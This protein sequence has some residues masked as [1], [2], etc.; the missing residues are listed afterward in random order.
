MRQQRIAVLGALSIAVGLAGSLLMAGTVNLDLSDFNDDVM[1]GMDDTMKALDSEIATHEVQ[2]VTRDTQSLIQG[3]KWAQDYFT[4]KGNLQDAIRWAAQGQ[5]LA[6]SL[7]KAAQAGDFDTS[8][9]K[10]D[11]LVKNCRACHDVYK[12]PDI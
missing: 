10:Y 11:A 6:D 3:L 5:E 2:S 4:R 7:A 9:N 12:P 8:L 1:R